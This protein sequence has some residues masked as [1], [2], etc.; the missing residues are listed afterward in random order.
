M[1]LSFEENKKA[2]TL[3][4]QKV[5]DE[6]G[7]DDMGKACRVFRAVLHAIRDRLPVNEAVHFAAQLPIIWKGIFYDQYNPDRVPVKIRDRQEWL[8]YIRSKNAFAANNDFQQDEEIQQSYEAVLRVLQK[9][10]GTEQLNKVQGFL[11]EE[12]REPVAA[13]QAADNSTKP[14]ATYL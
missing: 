11:S 12:I 3:L 4:Q 9:F 6:L 13:E 10:L 5:A 1:S 8:H 2:A 14:P 7:T